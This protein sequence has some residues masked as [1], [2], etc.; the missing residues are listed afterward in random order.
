MSIL[1]IFKTVPVAYF[2]AAF[3]SHSRLIIDTNMWFGE[4]APGLGFAPLPL[5]GSI[6]PLANAPV[7][8]AASSQ[9]F[10]RTFNR[11]VVPPVVAPVASVVPPPLAPVIPLPSRAYSIC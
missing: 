9:Y 8:T 10:E 11:L 4:K 6:P 3:L 1:D 7:V 5:A 2:N